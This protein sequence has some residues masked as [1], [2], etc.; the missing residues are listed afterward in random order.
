M[1]S[2][3]GAPGFAPP[4]Q[5]AVK[6][7]RTARILIADGEPAVRGM[8]CSIL[9]RAGYD[10]IEA[11]DGD[12]VSDACAAQCPD[13]VLI[14]IIMPNREGVETIAA[15]REIYPE[16]PIVAMSGGGRAG[17]S[18]FP[19]FSGKAG[20]NRMLMKP[21]RNAELLSAI[22]ECLL[23]A[24]RSAAWEEFAVESVEI[25]SDRAAQRDDLGMDGV[26]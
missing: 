13:L 15:L 19:D 14:D 2:D 23:P 26:A 21:M 17:S 5:V 11:E 9:R 1:R 25:D 7:L 3:P 12:Q 10:V 24:G 20:A 22:A 8:L 6:R 18:A 4:Q 16:L